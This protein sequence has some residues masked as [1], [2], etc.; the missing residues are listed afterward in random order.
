MRRWAEIVLRH[1]RWVM[2]LWAVIFV[3]GVAVTQ[4]VSDRMTIDF[5][6]P[7]Q[8]GTDTANA[9]IKT[10]GNGGNTS[11][12]L[13][14]VTLPDGSTVDDSAQQVGAAFA[15]I[16]K[17]DPRLRVLDEANSG[18]NVFRTKDDRTAYA[19]VFYPFPPAAGGR[20][21]DRDRAQVACRRRRPT[22]R[23]SASRV[24]T[25]SPSATQS[26]GTGVLVE[27]LLG[28]VGA[29]IVLLFVFAS[30]L[31]LLPLVVA[32]VSILTTFLFLLPLTYAHRRVV[33]RPVPGRADRP[34][35]RDRLL[36]A[37]RH[38]LARGARPRPRQPRRGR[39]GDGDRR[40]RGACSAA[41]RWRS[42]CSRWSCCRCR[43]CAASASAGR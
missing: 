37:A 6:L 25:R 14:T 34:R 21:A 22:A 33:H 18:D 12:L 16:E 26:G 5:G 28:A 2:A 13:V 39:R 17:D 29:L 7:G 9:I 35:R 27:T 31:A 4:T 32:A 15:A 42:A 41:S 10:V 36:A 20:P 43:S 11:P 19:L 38:P 30:F 24:R 8:P 1:R 40:P 23:P 3:A